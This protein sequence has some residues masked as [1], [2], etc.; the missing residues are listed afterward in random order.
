MQHW[1]D[2]VLALSDS[3]THYTIELSHKGQSLITG[4]HAGD[5][6]MQRDF[7]ASRCSVCGMVYA[8]GHEEDEKLHKAFHQGAVQGFKFQVCSEPC[9][10]QRLEAAAVY[11]AAGCT[12]LLCSKQDDTARAMR[13]TT[14]LADSKSSTP[15]VAAELLIKG[16]TQVRAG[17]IMDHP[18]IKSALEYSSLVSSLS[19]H[20]GF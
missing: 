1:A 20:G 6:P 16:S 7:G 2:N 15:A 3:H 8:K 13:V 19:S 4:L 5:L 9:S 14:A 12:Q 18:T 10:I 17:S 11:A